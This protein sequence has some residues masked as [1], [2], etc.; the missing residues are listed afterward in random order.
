MILVQNISPKSVYVFLYIRTTLRNTLITII[1][2]I[3]ETFLDNQINLQDNLKVLKI[4]SCGNCGFKGRS[5]E[6]PFA[7]SVLATNV[8]NFLGSKKFK[9]I[10]IIFKGL[11]TQRHTLLKSLLKESTLKKLSIVSIT[12]VTRA[13]YNGCRPKKRKRR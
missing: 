13:P 12:D 5:K 3:K 4:F 8:I 9:Y 2:N 1:E 7:Q 11:G 6:T 10:H